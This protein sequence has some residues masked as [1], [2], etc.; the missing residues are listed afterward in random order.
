MKRSIA[1]ASRAQKDVRESK[2]AKIQ[3]EAPKEAVDGAHVSISEAVQYVKEK[4]TGEEPKKK[5]TS[6]FR[7]PPKSICVSFDCLGDINNVKVKTRTEHTKNSRLDKFLRPDG[8]FTHI[9]SF[10]L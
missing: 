5:R 6:V 10:N 1:E 8:R 4:I 2:K 3:K 7:A 9:L